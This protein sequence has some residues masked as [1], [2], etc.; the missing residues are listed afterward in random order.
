MTIIVVLIALGLLLMLVEILLLPGINVAGIVGLAFCAGGVIVGFQQGTTQGFIALGAVVVG[1]VL[2]LVYALRA[3]TWRRV[4]LNEQIDSQ[5]GP[6]VG[7]TV[8]VGDNGV[9]LSRI[10]PMGKAI[11][12]G[13]TVEVSS[14]GELIDPQQPVVVVKVD[15]NLIVVKPQN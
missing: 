2:M 6:N 3:S 8:K 12:G 14:I 4:A 1:S 9:T 10:A 5:A 7:Q 15:A 13:Q 11:I